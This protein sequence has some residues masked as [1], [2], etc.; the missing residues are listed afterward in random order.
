MPTFSHDSPPLLLDD[1]DDNILSTELLVVSIIASISIGF[2]IG[3]LVM[4]LYRKCVRS[5]D[6]SLYN[7]NHHHN[8]MTSFPN[9]LG[10]QSTA[11]NC[12]P[13][14][15]CGSPPLLP[16]GNARSVFT[17]ADRCPCSQPPPPSTHHHNPPYP[18][19]L[20]SNPPSYLSNCSN[21]HHHAHSEP[22]ETDHSLQTSCRTS[23]HVIMPEDRLSVALTE[24][25]WRHTN[26]GTI[27]SH[28]H[29]N[30]VG[31]IEAEHRHSSG[32]SDHRH[33]SPGNL[34]NTGVGIRDLSPI[35]S[36]SSDTGTE[37]SIGTVADTGT[38]TGIRTPANV[39]GQN[40]AEHRHSSDP[41]MYQHQYAGNASSTGTGVRDL[42]PIMSVSS[43]TGAEV[44]I[45]TGTNTG[46]G[47]GIVT[48]A[49]FVRRR[50]ESNSHHS[51]SCGGFS[52]RS[53]G[54]G[55]HIKEPGKRETI[56]ALECIAMDEIRNIGRLQTRGKE[57][58]GE[59]GGGI[60]V[61]QA[62]FPS[63]NLSH[64]RGQH[65]THNTRHGN[66]ICQATATNGSRNARCNAENEGNECLRLQQNIETPNPTSNSSEL[67][68]NVRIAAAATVSTH[69]QTEFN[70]LNNFHEDGVVKYTPT[71][72]IPFGS[73]LLP[74]AMSSRYSGAV[75]RCFLIEDDD[76]AKDNDKCN[77]NDIAVD[78]EIQD[79]KLFSTYDDEARII[80]EPIEASKQILAKD[81]IL[82]YICKR[83]DSRGGLLQ[84]DRMGISLEV[85]PGAIPYGQSSLVSLVLNWDLNDNPHMEKREALI[86]PVV[87]C[88]PHSS[89]FQTACILKF[90]HCAFDNR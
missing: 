68:S 29:A 30:A 56:N 84:L 48:A 20:N 39:V 90:K 65:N 6:H 69:T 61:P 50:G 49:R 57:N 18:H 81:K 79:L 40:E 3:L 26:T 5:H 86:S 71:K 7:H 53:I 73:M 80:F 52:R 16:G 1:D 13:G 34:V 44:G 22:H 31:P 25:S 42:S 38:R 14:C 36:V 77:G 66:E 67:G 19:H 15:Q 63:S 23:T 59:V 32:S 62:I 72:Q 51:S 43:G 55:D 24:Q 64:M 78:C 8:D 12:Y 89:S 60:Q 47:T 76:N 37:A 88:G 28:E 45:E 17:I 70:S 21:Q 4:C 10:L 83:L 35:M 85:P 11:Y 82:V 54:R 2:L 58:E 87:Y 9:I 27:D 74:R 75:N 46:T 33:Q 41:S